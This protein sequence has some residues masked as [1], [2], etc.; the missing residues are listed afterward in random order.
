MSLHYRCWAEVDLGA[1]HENLA[2]RR[3]R[4]GPKVKILAVVKADAYGHG[5][6]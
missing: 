1:L 2:W 3:N 5:L 6:K 4:V